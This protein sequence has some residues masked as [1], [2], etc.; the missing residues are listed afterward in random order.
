[1]SFQI[2]IHYDNQPGFQDPHIWIWSP[3]S[4]VQA[5][6]P[7]TGQDTFGF[8]YDIS[9]QPP[10]FTL[11]PKFSFKFKDGPGSAG[12]WED[13]GLDRNYHS[14][15]LS[16]DNLV[17]DEIWC[18]GN[19]AFVYSVEP[20]A[21]EPVSAETFLGGLAFK[22]G[23]YVP[24][25]GGLSGL[26]ANLL[27]DGRVLFGLYQ[28]NA[29]RVYL[30]GGFNDWQRPGHEQP[31]PGKYI[32]LKRYRGYFDVPNTW[33]VVT[34]Q[35]QVGDEYKFFVQGGVPPDHKGRNQRY[36]TDPYARRLG[37][38]FQHN[39]AIIVDP[40]SFQWSDDN[41][42]TPDPSQLI[43]YELSVYGF[44]E[45]DPDI[46]AGN[47]GKFK[48]ISERIQTGYFDQLGVTALSLMPLAEFPSL[49]GPDTLGYDP[50]L[51]FTVERDFGSPDDLRDLVNT[52][53]QKGLAVL[54][55]QV[56]NHTSNN[57]NPLW[58]MILEHPA[59]AGDGGLYFNGTTPWGNR[60]ATEKADVQNML[61]DACK[62]LI[63]E[64]HVDGFRYDATHSHYMDHGFLQRLAGELKGFKPDVLLVAENLP[65]EPDL[66]RQGYDGYAQWGNL[67]HDKLKALLREGPFENGQDY[68][69][70]HLA[71]MFYF[72][73][74]DFASHTNNVVNYGE[75]H[76]EHSIPY[77]IH[78]TPALDNPAAKDRKG[79][80]GLFSTLVALG[81]PMLYMGQEFNTERPR[82]IVTVNWPADLGQH[83][84]F[85]WASRLNHLRRRYPGLKLHGYNPAEAGQFDWIIGPWMA[86]N[87]G[88]GR[89]VIGWRAR[90]NGFAHDTL[91]IM[92]NFENHDVQVDVDFGIP[93]IWLKLA[94]INRVNDVPPMGTNSVHD[95]SAIRTDGGNFSAF[96]LPSSSG[97]IYKWE[98]PR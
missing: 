98:A 7:A 9:D 88:G 24:G 5:D 16:S 66:N 65:N 97:F 6:F 62:L 46:Q 33:L 36:A 76:D 64:Y 59:R 81:Q 83:G 41:W 68:N 35:A 91:V 30:M 3:G 80:L 71:D 67:F 26:G 17:P 72:S 2:R 12:P 73:K 70:D 50:S 78:F 56:F 43:L 23:L 51:Y 42:A 47:R 14:L 34:E 54:L 27:A 52:A 4:A 18:Q 58:D 84:F 82:N 20:R 95:P 55:D 15:E 92:L 28:P 11:K 45:G 29:A 86:G 87:R 8:V 57:F 79:R 77:E 69:T 32:E 13:S 10:A 25:T 37:S 75:S 74:G 39:N 22:E 19:H 60:V 93:G 89:K 38:D 53:H 44:T 85:Q 48:G 31:D 1:M 40:T 94:D 90:P 96:T 61:I 49:Q 21:P 63:K